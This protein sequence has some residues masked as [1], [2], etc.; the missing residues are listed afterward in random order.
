MATLNGLF[1][2]DAVWHTAGTG[3]LS[4]PK[5]GRDAILGFFGE[6]M[7]RSNGTFSVTLVDLAGSGDRVFALQHSHGERQGK[8]IDH[9]VV[10]VF[11]IRNGVAT[12]V[13]EFFE[14]TGEADAFW[15]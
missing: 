5:K 7:E 12:E 4:G 11:E 6:L 2:E 1:A 14:D 15:A 10:N 8:V 9:D 3:V 13:T